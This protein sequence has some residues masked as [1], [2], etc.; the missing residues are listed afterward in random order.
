M[1]SDDGEDASIMV[2]LACFQL[3]FATYSPT[4]VDD[5]INDNNVYFNIYIYIYNFNVY[6]YLMYIYIYI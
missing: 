6:I 3:T 1:D 2:K 5:E 4:W